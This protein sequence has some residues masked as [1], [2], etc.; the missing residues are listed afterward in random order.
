MT[1]APRSPH[2]HSLERAFL[3][4]FP[5]CLACGGTEKLQV[6]HVLPFHLH[7]EQELRWDNLM[8]LCMGA[9]E[10][11]LHVGH[12]GD[13]QKYNPNAREDAAKALRAA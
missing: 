5:A 7:P 11:H 6:H 10:C 2:W 8:T 3:H 12:D 4:V 1:E 9:K 13:W